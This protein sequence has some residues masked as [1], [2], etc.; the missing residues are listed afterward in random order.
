MELCIGSRVGD[1]VIIRVG[2]ADYS[3]GLDWVPSTLDVTA[4][5]WHA[6]FDAMLCARDFASFRTELESLYATLSGSAAFNTIEEQLQL[7]CEVD[8]LG[9]I[10]I[11]C[12]ASDRP[13]DGNRLSFA[14]QLDQSDLPE[15]IDQL[16]QIEATCSGDSS[17]A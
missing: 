15:I 9:H 5:A 6:T 10:A 8:N 14:L 12:L 16:R 3:G 17:L 4:G 13:G 7:D 11:A 1:H 2:E